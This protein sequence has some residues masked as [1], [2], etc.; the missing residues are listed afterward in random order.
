MRDT[1]DNMLFPCT[2]NPARGTLA[3]AKRDHLAWQR[4]MA[5]SGEV[6]P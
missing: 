3:E 5:D 1:I 4:E 2:G 6:Q